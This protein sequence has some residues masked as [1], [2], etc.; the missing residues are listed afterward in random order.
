MKTISFH[1]F[2]IDYY[3][4]NLG[5]LVIEA[6]VHGLPLPTVK[7]YKDNHLIKPKKDKVDIFVENKEIYQCLMIR[8][9]TSVSGTYTILAEN[10]AGKKR[11]THIVDFVTKYPFYNAFPG[12]RHADKD[13]NNFVEEILEHLPKDPNKK[14]E[15]E[16]EKGAKDNIETEKTIEEPQ[17]PR[18]V[19]VAEALKS[20]EVVEAPAVVDEEEKP[21]KKHHRSHHKKKRRASTP[22]KDDGLI[23][24]EDEVEE[25]SEVIETLAVEP[26]VERR[27]QVQEESQEPYEFESFRIFNNSKSLKFSGGLSNQTVIEGKNIKMICA[28][29]GPLPILKWFKN[30]KPV[31][32]SAT[33][34]NN[35]GEG[36]GQVIIENIQRSDAAV[37]TCS[38]KNQFNEITTEA[39]IKVIPKSVLPISTS[40][41]QFTRVLGEY[42]HIL[43]DDLVLNA[44]CRGVPDPKIKWT[45]DGIEISEKTD[46]RYM[47]SYD[48]DGGYKFCIH[49]PSF[50]DNAIYGCQAENSTGKAKITHKVIFHEHVRHTHPQFVYHKE[51]F[52]KPHS[53]SIE[54]SS[55]NAEVE[56]TQAAGQ[57]GADQV[58]VPVTDSG[59]GDQGSGQTNGVSSNGE[60]VGG[61]GDGNDDGDKRNNE[62][63]NT[64]DD[65]VVEKEKDDEE[66]EEEESIQKQE[67]PYRST[68]RRRFDGP[69]SEPYVIRDSVKKIQYDVKLKDYTVMTGSNIKLYCQISGPQPVTKW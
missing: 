14:P 18:E 27:R 3:D 48:H 11:F 8:P 20:E 23:D 50:V 37:Y 2:A 40:K 43:E 44:H 51:S 55:V 36:L 67:K 15:V 9:D 24:D 52:I 25:S 58:Q 10:K 31:P 65:E 46:P 13:L 26:V 5:G 49:K 7:F 32:W 17:M 16:T 63:L 61:A 47:F 41:P 21:K 60:T 35:S 30:G 4:H 39:V 45:K 22:S 64:N 34:R 6:H 19:A 62:K 1:L 56:I 59:S 53:I 57:S 68:R 42:Y 69:P 28:V 38:A 29:S 54:P 66:E 33:I 12:M